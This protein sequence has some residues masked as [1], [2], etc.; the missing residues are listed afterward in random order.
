MKYEYE[1]PEGKKVIIPRGRWNKVFGKRGRAI[2]TR[3]E[4]YV[5]DD[6]I[7]FH[8]VISPM[9]KIVFTLLLPIFFVIGTLQWG[10]KET[11]NAI[12]DVYLEKKRGK[13]SSDIVWNNDQSADVWNKTMKM[14]DTI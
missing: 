8:H 7:I 5:T 9:G 13:F 11:V 6:R 10:V 12:L 4:A 1:V 3:T 2:V 14:L